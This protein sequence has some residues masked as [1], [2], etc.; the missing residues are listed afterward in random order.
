MSG[1][2]LE[3]LLRFHDI[4]EQFFYEDKGDVKKETSQPFFQYVVFRLTLP[5]QLALSLIQ[6]VTLHILRAIASTLCG[7]LTLDGRK[8]LEG[9]ND[10]VS[11]MIETVALVLFATL[12]FFLPKTGIKASHKFLNLFHEDFIEERQRARPLE[13][14]SK[15][16]VGIVRGVFA[17]PLGIALSSLQIINGT[18]I[19]RKDLVKDG[20][21]ALFASFIVP[22]IAL[23]ATCSD[24]TNQFVHNFHCISLVD[25]YTFIE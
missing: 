10:I 18:L 6:S 7:I 16:I 8:I 1:L 24:K 22:F 23:S 17:L 14:L 11:C 3:S 12:T 20:C 5:I 21:V 13:G 25:D 4:A 15:V 19:G 9:L 2:H